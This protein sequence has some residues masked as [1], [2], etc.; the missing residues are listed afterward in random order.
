MQEDKVQ[1]AASLQ[2][3]ANGCGINVPYGE[4]PSQPPP[5]IFSADAIERH[6]MTNPL[7]G[8]YIVQCR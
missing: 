4:S 2:E 6:F 8:T 3:A 1:M 7:A 5:A